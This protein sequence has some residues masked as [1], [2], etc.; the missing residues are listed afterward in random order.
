MLAEPAVGLSYTLIATVS[1]MCPGT[2]SSVAG[3]LVGVTNPSPS[4]IISSARNP[5]AVL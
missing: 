5:V 3:L 1:N 2:T 4:T